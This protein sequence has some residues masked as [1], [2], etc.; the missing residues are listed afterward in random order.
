M[1]KKS[2]DQKERERRAV[3]LGRLRLAWVT[4]MV[5]DLDYEELRLAEVKARRAMAEK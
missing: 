5:R 1:V 3:E 2:K 4:A